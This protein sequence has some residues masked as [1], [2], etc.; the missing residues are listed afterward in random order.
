MILSKFSLS[1]KLILKYQYS[2]EMPILS[3]KRYR[4]LLGSLVIPYLLTKFRAIKI[5]EQWVV[6]I[7]FPDLRG[8]RT[9]ALFYYF[10]NP[11]QH[12]FS[13]PLFFIVVK[14]ALHSSQ[15]LSIRTALGS[16]RSLPTLLQSPKHLRIDPSFL[17][18]ELF[19]SGCLLI[20]FFYGV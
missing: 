18:G 19:P 14:M 6:L 15:S 20:N 13:P 11:N 10:P 16:S 3:L 5:Y 9:I 1:C 2:K 12:L 17:P 7:H 4:T 8:K